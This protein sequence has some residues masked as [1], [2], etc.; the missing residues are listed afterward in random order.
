M[1]LTQYNV[2]DDSRDVEGSGSG[3]FEGTVPKFTWT[4]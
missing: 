4:E 1:T 2:N 3:L